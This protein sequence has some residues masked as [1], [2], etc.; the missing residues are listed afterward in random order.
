MARHPRPGTDFFPLTID[1]EEK[2]YAARQD[3]RQLLPPRGPAF[4]GGDPQRAADRPAA[5]PALPEEHAQRRAGRHHR[6]V[7]RPGERA[8][9]ARHRRRLGRA[10]HLGDPVRRARQLRARRLHRRRVR[11]QPDVPAARR[12][13]HRHH[14]RRHAQRDHDG[15]GRR[16]GSARG[17][18]PRR[19][20]VRAAAEPDPHR[21]AGR[22]DRGAEAGEV[23]LRARLRC[24]TS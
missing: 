8:R 24:R 23:G 17:R 16:A 13:Q 22:D 18:H 15:R 10:L 19:D 11:R 5:A 4:D 7:R 2:M 14:R 1:F 12:E 9:R 3:P 21:P 20:G 6:A